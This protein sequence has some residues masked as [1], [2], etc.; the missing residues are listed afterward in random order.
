MKLA[1]KEGNYNTRMSCKKV[2][3][4]LQHTVSVQNSWQERKNYFATFQT[5]TQNYNKIQFLSFKNN[6]LERDI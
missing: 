4:M 3:L 1:L 2:I 6:S 5:E